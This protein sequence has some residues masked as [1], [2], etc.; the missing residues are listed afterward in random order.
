MIAQFLRALHEH[1]RVRV[2]APSGPSQVG[3]KTRGGD[4][5]DA[6]DVAFVLAEFEAVR[7][8]EFPGEAPEYAPAAGVWSATLFYR[9]C[10]AVLFRDLDEADLDALLDV[11]PPAAEPATLHYSVDLTFRFLPDLLKFAIQAAPADRLV[12]KLREWANLWP[13]SSVGIPDVAPRS[14]DGIVA[15]PGLLQYYVDRILARR[16]VSRLAHPLVAAAVRRSIG[17]YV[18]RFPEFSLVPRTT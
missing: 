4:L 1:G 12:E 6:A 13:C 16:D 18:E 11:P 5:G 17:P 3:Q 7:R 10:Q 15:H 9:A 8:G 2:G 14:L